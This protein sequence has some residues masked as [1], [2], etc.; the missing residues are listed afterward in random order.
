MTTQGQDG[1]D[2]GSRDAEQQS[3]SRPN[4]KESDPPEIAD[5]PGGTNDESTA[6]RT[7]SPKPPPLSIYEATSLRQ[8]RTTI[9]VAIAALFV[10]SAI[11]SWQISVTRGQLDVMRDQVEQMKADG[12]QTDKLIAQNE[13]Q[14]VALQDAA[15][16]AQQGVLVAQQAERPWMGVAGKPV[17]ASIN[18]GVNRT[19]LVLSFANAGKS[20]ARVVELGS[21]Y[22]FGSSV[23]P[24]Y[25]RDPRASRRETGEIIVVPGLG[26]DTTAATELTMEDINHMLSEKDTRLF[27]YGKVIYED[28]RTNTRY[29]TTVCF[30]KSRILEDTFISCGEYNDA[31]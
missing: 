12:K 27:V 25:D 18:E 16:A 5:G 6:G 14:I 9:C 19:K 1:G 21:G 20:P 30:F 24:D 2:N 11:L 23:K 10:N 13:R 28:L 31:T 22:N 8:T 17:I 4:G 3:S 15:N 29:T 26:V 7:G